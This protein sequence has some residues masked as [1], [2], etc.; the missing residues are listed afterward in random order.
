MHIELPDGHRLGFAARTDVGDVMHVFEQHYAQ[1][2]SVARGGR[3]IGPLGHVS[4]RA[5]NMPPDAVDAAQHAGKGP[6]G[7]IR[8]PQPL[9]CWWCTTTNAPGTQRCQQF[10]KDIG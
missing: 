6:T 9:T 8:A 4:I 1:Q 2:G 10:G 5:A 3:L 7:A